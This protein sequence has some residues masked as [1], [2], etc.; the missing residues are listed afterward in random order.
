MINLHGLRKF[1]LLQ[2][3]KGL[4]GVSNPFRT[5]ILTFSLTK[6]EMQMFMQLLTRINPEN[7]EYE[8]LVMKIFDTSKI[9]IE[10]IELE[11]DEYR[12]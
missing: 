12:K 11:D 8:D 9:R 3:G 10:E 4:L 1:T 2:R 7:K 5:Y 6:R